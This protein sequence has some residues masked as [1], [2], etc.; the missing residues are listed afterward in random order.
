M[1]FL[2]I[3]SGAREPYQREELG[4][5]HR[6]GRGGRK[7][8]RGAVCGTNISGQSY[9]ILLAIGPPRF[10]SGLQKKQATHTSTP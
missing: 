6:R 8:K 4:D 3:P 10:A 7:G 5:F 9:K 1:L 2:K